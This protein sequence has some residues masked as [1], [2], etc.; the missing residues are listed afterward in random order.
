[1]Y[2][3]VAFNGCFLHLRQKKLEIYNQD[4]EFIK[5]SR[6]Y[7]LLTKNNYKLINWVNADLIFA[8]KDFK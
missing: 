4:I 1:M 2:Q 8:K 6:I 3:V 5:N 7:D